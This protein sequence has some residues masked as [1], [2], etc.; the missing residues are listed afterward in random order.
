MLLVIANDPH[1]Q[2]DE[3][4]RKIY[5]ELRRFL[6]KNDPCLH[7]RSDRAMRRDRV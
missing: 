7:Y 2:D 5:Y 4:K 3:N 6:W 1:W